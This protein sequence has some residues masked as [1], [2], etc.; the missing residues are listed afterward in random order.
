MS[1]FTPRGLKIRLPME[2]C[3]TLLSRLEQRVTPIRVLQTT[4]G[5]ELLPPFAATIVA[6]ICYAMQIPPLNI[7][8]YVFVTYIFM[9]LLSYGG[10]YFFPF[11]MLVS[12]ST[13]YSYISGK[14]LLTGA[15][16]VVGFIMVGWQGAA[17][18][19]AGRVSGAVITEIVGLASSERNFINAY[20]IHARKAGASVDIT[21]LEKE[22]TEGRWLQSFI[23]F[24]KEF[25]ELT[26]RYT[27]DVL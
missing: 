11:S 10:F 15:T 26:K 16:C 13:M 9:C 7:G 12:P 25:P 22:I 24:E 17:A 5:L 23:R 3:F 18:Y 27:S 4:E 21:T 8:S 20:R 2:M 6:L 1:I 14:G 19:I